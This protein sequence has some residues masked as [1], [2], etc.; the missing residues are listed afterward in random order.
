MNLSLIT[1]NH[2]TQDYIWPKTRTLRAALR[3]RPEPAGAEDGAAAAAHLSLEA[4]E[5][6]KRALKGES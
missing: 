3:E 1:F 2:L 5:R 4:R 6:I